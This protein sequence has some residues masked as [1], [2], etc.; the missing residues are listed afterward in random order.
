MLSMNSIS[1]QCKRALQCICYLIKKKKKRKPYLTCLS[2]KM[3]TLAGCREEL[4][5]FV[6]QAGSPGKASGEAGTPT[7]LLSQP[8]EIL[9]QQW[10]RWQ[11]VGLSRPS[12]VSLPLLVTPISL[13]HCKRPHLETSG[14]GS[15][16]SFLL[17]LFIK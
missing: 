8:G 2:F 16:D 15:M 5:P 7:G 11:R 13:H 10:S 3:W 6:D 4:G 17:F 12:L 14:H 1:A 9:E